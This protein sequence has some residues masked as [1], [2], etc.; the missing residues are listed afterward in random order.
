MSVMSAG[1]AEAEEDTM[2]TV[3]TG[4]SARRWVV[5]GGIWSLRAPTAWVWL[6]GLAY[7]LILALNVATSLTPPRLSLALSVPTTGRARMAWVL[8]GGALWD[9]GVRAGDAV[10]ALDGR[11]P[12]RADTGLWSGRRLRVRTGPRTTVEV[13]AARLP[14]ARVTW[15]LLLLSP[16]FLLLATLIVL[17]APC[18]AVG[19]AAYLLFA[20]AA[21]A[22]A[23]AP[24]A[25][26]DD[27]TAAVAEWVMLALFAGGFVGFFLT[28]PTPRGTPR[29]RAW[30][31]APPF[32]GVLLG[33][34]ALGWPALYTPA[35]LAR[36]AALL[37]YLLLGIGLLIRSFAT[38]RGRAER[39]GLA[40][41]GAGSAAAV[42]PFAALYLLPTV[43]G[44]APLAA[45]EQAILALALLPASFTYAIL[46][47]NAL[48][49]HLLQRWLV[50]GLLWAG[51]LVPFAAAV[52]ARHWLLGAL[53]E[54]GRTL[55]LATALALL[56][57]L[58]FRWLYD[59]LR[60]WLDRWIFKDSYDYRSSLQ[61]L[62]R[63]LS[64]AG[65]LDT[66]GATLRRLMNLD[67]AVLLVHDAYDEHG[68]RAVGAAGAYQE[69][70][71][72][73][74]VEAARETPDAPRVASLAYGYPT[75]LLVPL[76]ARDAVVGHLCLGPK[77]SGEPF[78]AEDHAL[79]ATLSGHLAALVRNEPLADELRAQVALLQAQKATL[80][81]LNERLE[82][83]HEEERAHLVADIH[84][85]PLQTAL[86]LRHQLTTDGRGRTAT[87][88]HLALSQAIVNQL[89]AL[90][91]AVR[92]PAL[93][94][95][96]LAGAIE[97]LALDLT[98]RAGADADV[99]I[100]LDIDAEFAGAPLPPGVDVVLY[101]AA[102]EA[103]NNSLR[104][105]RPRAIDLTL[106]RHAG[107]VGLCVAD[108]GAGFAAPARV[109][110]LAETGHLGLVGL[111]HRV[112]RAGGRLRVTSAL[113]QGTVV[114]IELPIEGG[115]G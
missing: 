70:L 77:A 113:G 18:R 3:Q 44:R 45:A 71:L 36:M 62:S 11:P 42:L 5:A 88:Q 6:L 74:L 2:A 13:D 76:R 27:V 49:V 59:R 98:E 96:G 10:L 112:Q 53:S 48:D 33:L 51:L 9:Q 22:L 12:A 106:R 102:Q 57:G 24:G 80:D 47:H 110:D 73:A 58:T 91:T 72:P 92:P 61:H 86:Y 26:A 107:V 55:V 64:L 30:L 63:D 34:A 35:Y 52:F 14:D 39:R 85:E 50:H 31:L 81:T 15:P 7:G 21:Y 38:A 56:A 23:L 8:P 46:R 67:F 100:R 16:W 111:Q 43:L 79:L 93:D 105:A 114:R 25:D 28:Y 87:V 20:S 17:R 82:R 65:H 101:R 95:L 60:R 108:D 103:L 1:R 54:P 90:C 84:D 94:E 41:I 104:H 32:A 78:R 66:L 68:V 4:Y 75:V 109:D 97:V 115:T 99:S 69:A 83:A 29:P 19:R 89:H 37:G 40:I